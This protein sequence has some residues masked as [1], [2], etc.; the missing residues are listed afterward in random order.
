MPASLSLLLFWGSLLAA[1]LLF[2]RQPPPLLPD[3]DFTDTYKGLA[4]L[5]VLYHH[6]RIYNAQEFWY[7][8][9]GGE[10]FA[11]VTMF[12]F[13]SG[14]GL[15]RSQL[16]RA[17]TPSRFLATRF[18]ALIP[19]V[20][21][22][23]LLRGLLGPLWGAPV[24][25][26]SDPVA[27][28]G[29]REW[30]LIAIW[31]YYFAFIISWSVGRSPIGRG[32]FI[33]ASCL[34]LA[35]GLLHGQENWQVAR[36]WL[37]FP[38][39]FALGVLLAPHMGFVLDFCR[40]RAVAVLGVTGAILGLAW[41]V[42]V[43]ATAPTDWLVDVAFIPFSIAACALLYRFRLTSRF[44]TFLG[45]NSLPLFLLQVPLLKN[46]WLIGVWHKD[47]LGLLVTWAVIFLLAAG[48]GRL[49]G[50][51]SRGIA[52]VLP[53]R[54]ETLAAGRALPPNA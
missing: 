54:Q 48:V 37:R 51:L 34:L 45:R 43:G 30:F 46:G 42:P 7:L 49:Q 50:L 19:G 40:Q 17:Y 27:L 18:L 41:S 36:L 4:M 39:S 16:K 28:L 12:F 3:K 14:V 2:R 1:V 8:M 52:S 10:A 24:S 15:G 31:A 5:L 38:F 26:E 47:M 6:S 32:F 9:L 35:A 13:I 20:V 29:L 21:V 44:W 11:G 25:L 22:C 53:G 33:V 23:M